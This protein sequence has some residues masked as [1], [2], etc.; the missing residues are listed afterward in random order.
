MTAV[1]HRYLS[2]LADTIHST[3]HSSIFGARTKE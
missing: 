2:F 3:E 1:G